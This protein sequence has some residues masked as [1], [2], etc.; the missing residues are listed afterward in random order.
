MSGDPISTEGGGTEG[1]SE[2]ALKEARQRWRDHP[3]CAVDADCD[4]NSV[5]VRN[6]RH[7]N[8]VAGTAL[9]VTMQTPAPVTAPTPLSERLISATTE[10]HALQI[11]AMRQQ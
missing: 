4:G 5:L 8:C 2:E 3:E 1:T 6:V 9:G 11:P 10:M 7:R